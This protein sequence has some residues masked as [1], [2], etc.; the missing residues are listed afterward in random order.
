MEAGEVDDLCES[1][2]SDFHHGD[3]LILRGGV[4]LIEEQAE[5]SQLEEVIHSPSESYLSD[6]RSLWMSVFA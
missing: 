1:E 3:S 2:V 6:L 5:S 4:R